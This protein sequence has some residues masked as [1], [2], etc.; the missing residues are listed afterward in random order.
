MK[1]YL[2]AFLLS[3]VGVVNFYAQEV[4]YS[5]S[6]P[7]STVEGAQIQLRYVLRV[8]G[9]AGKVDLPV[10][11]ENELDGFVVLYGPAYSVSQSMRT[12]N[13]QTTSEGN[14]TFTYTLTANKQGTFTF[15]PTTIKVN[16]KTYTSNTST[17]KV[18]PPDKD[19]QTTNGKPTQET[20]STSTSKNISPNDAFIRA[21][22]SK[23]KGMEQEAY[24][25]TFRLY[26]VLSIRQL[27]KIQFPE[28]EGFMVEDLDIPESLQGRLENYN[29]K[30]YVTYN[31][32]KMLIFPQRSG[33]MTIPSGSIDIVFYVKSGQIIMDPFWGPQEGMTDVKR[34]LKTKPETMDISP[35]PADGKPLG[36]SGA[37]GSF[38]F[39]PTISKTDVVANDGI[40]ITLKIKGTGNM[41][42]IKNPE[43]QFPTEFETYDAKVTNDL[44]VTENGLS[45]T[46]TIEYLFIPRYPGKYTIPPINFTY[47]DT[48]AKEYKTLSSEE[49]TINVAKDPNA[50]ATNSGT[51]YSSQREVQIDQD[52]RYLK[53]DDYDFR[54][55]E[56]F[57]FG[58]AKYILLYYLAPLL[59]FVALA[60]YYRKRI[61]ANAD[62]VRMR[63][64]KANKVASKRLKLAKKYLAA[65][66]KDSFYEEV[67]RAVWGYLSDKLVIPVA[68]LN[69]ENIETELTGYGVDESLI[70]QF[71]SILD[72]CE[73]ARYA[74]SES[75]E[76][77]DR[78][79]AETVDA[80]GKMENV[81]KK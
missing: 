58:S 25:V 23:K 11:D 61:K 74:P 76:A 30:N 7:N 26:S 38:D 70:K 10:L 79:Y 81:I 36:F 56:D 32:R 73:F 37:V 8:T 68:D 2:I 51:S 72:T 34:T 14:W 45:G 59:I 29:G 69:R 17:I 21:I 27:D 19:A 54:D 63:T 20:T 6:A 64:K 35:Y 12:I 28:F 33:K 77:M 66:N 75:D 71:I 40:T 57:L 53:T 15:P 22:F 80:I 18:L 42:L 67:L 55:T 78:T 16:G 46:R 62:V 49:Y 9:D 47:Y 13:G 48:K 52:I 44:K 24:V 50:S 41:K 43:I 39:E 3:F 60:I 5:I 4:T 31:L 65:H 1:K